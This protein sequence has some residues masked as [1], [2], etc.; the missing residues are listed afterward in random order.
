MDNQKFGKFI[1][2]LRKKS[3]MTQKEL[4]EKLNVTDKAVSKW[5]RGL[6]FPDITIINSIA[7]VF[8]ITAS[9]VLNAEIGNKEE[10][11]VEKAVQEAVEKVT[12]EKEKKENRNRKIKKVLK[13]VSIIVFVIMLILQMGYLFVMRPHG[14][15]YVSDL[16]FYIVNEFIIISGVLFLCLQLKKLKSLKIASIIFACIL[17]II[18]IAFMINNAVHT[19]SIVSF[20]KIFSNELVLKQ[21]KETGETQFYRNSKMIIFAKPNEYFEYS[22]EGKIKHQWLTNDICNITYKDKDGN[23]RDFV[24]TY[25][26]RGDTVSYYYV[27]N[28]LLGRWQTQVDTVGNTNLIVDSKGIKV[29]RN[30]KSEQFKYE[31]CK[32]FGTTALVLYK[33]ETPKYVIALNEDC[34]IDSKT[35]IIK[36]GGTITFCDVSMNKTIKETLNCTIHKNDDLTNYSGIDIDAY[37]YKIDNGILYI[38]YDGENAIEVPGDFS[39]EKS[40]YNDYNYQISD[41]KTVFFYT[42]DEKTYLVYSDDMGN[43]WNT[44]ELNNDIDYIQ[45]MHFLDKDLGFM[46][47][48]NDSALAGVRFGSILKTTDGGKSWSVINN[49]IG[50]SEMK[51]FRSGSQILFTDENTG[52][53]TMPDAAGDTSDLDYSTDGGVNFTKVSLGDEHYDYYE[54]P[55]MKDGKLYLKVGQGNDGDYNG[56]D[57]KEYCSEDNG[58][59]WNE[60]DT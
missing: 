16:I 28:S 17:S 60:I 48:F 53:L 31:D 2:D 42:S 41:Y 23:L 33:E 1:R 30:K 13:I 40:E 55:T 46:L 18:N 20:S 59:T 10:V 9:E 25:G 26:A 8:G 45:N 27:F 21:D 57:S 7:E 50:D 39:N 24:A 14:Y 3:N 5:E 54:I 44:V 34:E 56:G 47:Q 35:D 6:G 43:N 37:D 58:K 36:S 29:T 15:E 49:G 12:K 4:G 52:F 11:D 32:Q 19:K 22:V 38:S 51:I